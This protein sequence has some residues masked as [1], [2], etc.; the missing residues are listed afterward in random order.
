M[1][2]KS[3]NM[4]L[5]WILL[6]ILFM[7]L[8]AYLWFS[9]SNLQTEYNSLSSENMELE[10]LHTELDQEYKTAL[11]DLEDLRGDNQELNELIDN[12]KSDFIQSL[13]HFWN[14]WAATRT[15][16][17]LIVCGSAASWMINELINHRGGLHNRVTEKIRVEPFKLKEAEKF[18]E[19]LT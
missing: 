6:S 11:Q 14:S 12:Q 4:S 5:I 2:S 9:K 3:N 15:D 10:K 1:S 19:N 8:S 17:I 7:G 18:E 13:E 16:I